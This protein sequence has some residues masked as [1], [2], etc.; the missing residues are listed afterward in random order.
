[1]YSSQHAYALQAD[2]GKGR[3]DQVLFWRLTP[4]PRTPPA[5]AGTTKAAVNAW[6]LS[7]SLQLHNFDLPTALAEYNLTQTELARYLVD[8]GV[9]IGTRSQF[10][11]GPKDRVAHASCST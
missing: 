5:P 4:L 10:S 8:V 2:L 3:T 11:S 1:M 9:S 7:K 6:T